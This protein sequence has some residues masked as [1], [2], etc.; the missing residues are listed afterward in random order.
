MSNNACK[1]V[2]I[3]CASYNGTTGQCT[4]CIN[5]YFYQNNSCVFPALFDPNCNY[6]ESAYCS[7]CSPGYYLSNYLCQPVSQACT[8]FD[9]SRKQCLQCSS[10]Q[11]SGPSCV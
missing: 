1:A 2:S 8:N 5:G 11:P 7:S 3:T 6:Y 10:G 4:S 9:Y